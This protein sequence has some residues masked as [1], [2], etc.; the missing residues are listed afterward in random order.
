MKGGIVQWIRVLWDKAPSQLACKSFA[1]QLYPSSFWPELRVMICVVCDFHLSARSVNGLLSSQVGFSCRRVLR[2]N[3]L[4]LP[5]VCSAL[6]SQV[7]F[8]DL[9][10][11]RRRRTMK[12]TSC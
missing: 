7:L 3:L 2:A 10:E 9:A 5:K 11:L 6:R 8:S 1:R 4:D 12:R